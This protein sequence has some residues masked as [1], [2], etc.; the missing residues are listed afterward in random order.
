[1]GFI[2]VH[3]TVRTHLFRER[4]E[5]YGAVMIPFL[6]MAE[7]GYANAWVFGGGHLGLDL[8]SLMAIGRGFALELFIY[9]CFRI[10]RSFAQA[11]RRW[12]LVPPLLIGA[13]A[14]IVSAGMNL[15]WMAQSPEMQVAMHAVAQFMPDWMAN[16]FRVGLGLLFP[17]G[18]GLFALYD[19]GHL[20]EEML[21]SSHLDDRA[22]Y[23]HRAELGRTGY[24]KSLKRAA[25]KTQRKYD[26]ICDADAEN[27][28]ERVKKGDLSF[29]ANDYQKQGGQAAVTRVSP[30]GHLSLPPLSQRPNALPP[31]AA[32]P[33]MPPL[34]PKQPVGTPNW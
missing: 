9:V 6:F 8:N 10:V 2:N 31:A 25:K 3:R 33:P 29:G 22:M 16:V 4:F 32:L 14:M 34:S 18:V 15:G 11:G 12:L 20:V 21:K 1:M 19:V 17:V 28:V 7:S 13:V 23:V 5:V 26:A 24:L 30:A 27:I